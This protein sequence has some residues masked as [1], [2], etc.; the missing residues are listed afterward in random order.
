MRGGGGGGG[1]GVMELALRSMLPGADGR[2][3]CAQGGGGARCNG[4]N[5]RAAVALLLDGGAGHERRCA[6]RMLMRG[7][8]RSSDGLTAEGGDLI[9]GRQQRR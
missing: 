1:G 7:S 3:L 6:G 4:G 9:D 5:A 2:V 8:S